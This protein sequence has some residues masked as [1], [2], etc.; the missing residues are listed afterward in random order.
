MPYDARMRAAIGATRAALAGLG[1]GPADPRFL[2]HGEHEPA[3]GAPLL[4]V[5]CSGGRDSMALAAVARIVCA[6]WGF[7]CG[8]VVV[9]HG[10]QDG[11]DAVAQAAA[12]RCRT[13]GLAPVAVRRVQ[14]AGDAGQ[15][16]EAAARE[17]RYAALAHEAARLGAAAV[18]LAHTRDD[19]AETVL[20]GLLRSGGLDA[21]A[22]MPPRAVHHGVVFL[23][24]L[25]DLTRQDTTGICR[26]LGLDWWDDPTNGPD[27]A[28]DDGPLPRDYPLRSRVRHDL[29]PFLADF[30]GTDVT[31][32]LAEGAR[33]AQRDRDCLDALADAAG[34]RAVA[35]AA[36]PAG[37]PSGL[38]RPGDLAAI[39][40][41]SLQ[42]EHPAIRTR[43]IARALAAAGIASNAR[44][45][46]AIDRL[47][48]DWHGQGGVALPGG[49][50]ANRQ[51]HV[52]HVCQ[53][54]AH[55][56]R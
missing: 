2:E 20:L 52:I 30:A 17:A 49:H 42:A 35:L 19:Q 51:K 10:L 34:E 39:D 23:R 53:D 21:V 31:C 11:S 22:G 27:A 36:E 40:A 45:V 32:R 56:N 29:V 13:L 1:L 44:Q 18:L 46:V 37:G 16:V 12:D 50:S 33:L 38:L 25:L 43:V 9:D 5:A 24:P 15:G 41:R 4:L 28:A 47:I 3:P 54:G 26:S 7:G 48:A 14:V 55:A 8:A 6:A